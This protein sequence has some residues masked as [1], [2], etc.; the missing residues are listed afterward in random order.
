MFGA[1]GGPLLLGSLY[2]D[3]GGDR[4]SYLVVRRLHGR[5]GV[6]RARSVP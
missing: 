6:G 4:T 5:R 2:D 3:A 1:A